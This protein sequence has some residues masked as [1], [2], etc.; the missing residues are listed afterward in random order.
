MRFIKDERGVAA[1][2]WALMLLPLLVVVAAALD[3]NHRQTTDR[4]MK[5]AADASAIA[6]ARYAMESNASEAEIKKM[7]ADYFHQNLALTNYGNSLVPEIEFIRDESVSVTAKYQKPTFM[8]ALAGI[9]TLPVSVE[10]MA[11]YSPPASVE[12]VLVLDNSYSMVGAKMTALRDAAGLFVD[13]VVTDGNDSV[14][15]AIVPFNNFVNIGTTYKNE[16]WLDVPASYSENY[17][18]CSMDVAATKANGCTQY[19]STC[20]NDGVV[21]DCQKWSCPKGKSTVSTCTTKTRTYNWYGCVRSRHNP[22]DVRDSDFDKF[23]VPAHLQTGSGGCGTPLQTLT[24]DVNALKKKIKDLKPTSET[25]IATG[26]TW[27]LRVLSSHAP[28]DQGTLE[29]GFYSQGGQKIVILM[30]DGAN[31]RSANPSD[32]NHNKTN[33]VDA[34][35]TTERACDEIKDYGA[36]VYTIAFDVDDPDLA[37]LLSDCASH[38][39]RFFDAKDSTALTNAFRAISIDLR[40]IA[41]AK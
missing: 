27:G 20:S 23:Q 2:L 18:S 31:T 10:S 35:K 11:V 15:V 40:D 34:N 5:A 24:S 21:S 3:F 36:E 33:V 39:S 12:A 9:R 29:S 16:P 17:N 6:A 4:E 28:F 26:L 25:Y 37:E 8:L 13:E 14:R 7:A 22:Y 19:W 41:L 30:S 1:T 38:P 32:G